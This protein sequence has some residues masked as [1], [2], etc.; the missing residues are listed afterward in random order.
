MQTRD[1]HIHTNFCDGGREPEEY[2]VSA[3]E[4][5]LTCI[6]FSVHSYVPFDLE[7]CI[8]KER[9]PEYKA[10][11]G[12][13]KRKYAD[14]IQVLCG[15]E[16][17]YYSE[18]STEGYDYVIGSY[19]YFRTP[20][21]EFIPLD[22]TFA[23]LEKICR[24]WFCGDFMS[25]CEDYYRIEAEIPKKINADII[26]HFDLITKFNEKNPAIDTKNPR[27]IKAY[28][29]AAKALVKYNIPFEINTGA[30]TRNYRTLP[31]PSDDILRTV[32]ALGGKFTLS[33][34]AHKPEH[35]AYGFGE[36]EKWAK[37][38]GAVLV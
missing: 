24:D 27:Y 21:G 2:V 29:N 12:A 28:T 31:Y 33:S 16:Q 3:I 26:G 30:I 34:D 22:L 1:L 35:I 15:V 25:L 20:D 32:T 19:H 18:C 5:G 9:I 14:K 6:G 13:L 10:E 11:I 38:N 8:A 36:Y 37:E 17:D 7:C 4:K 23:V